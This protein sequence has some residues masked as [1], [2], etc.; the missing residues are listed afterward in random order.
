VAASARPVGTTS[1]R[2]RPAAEVE[3]LLWIAAR[4]AKQ[5]LHFDFLTFQPRKTLRRSHLQTDSRLPVLVPGVV[6][7]KCRFL[8]LRCLDRS[9]RG[10]D[11]FGHG[12]L[13]NSHGTAAT[14]R[15]T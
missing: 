10:H 11:I 4:F 9:R 3:S 13:P 12:L 15:R 5:S 8:A 6:D 1:R 2:M 14:G 7:I